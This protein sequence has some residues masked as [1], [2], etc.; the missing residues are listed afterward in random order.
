MQI[1]VVIV[2]QIAKVFKLVVLNKEQW[3]YTILISLVPLVIIEM[4]KKFEEIKF[5]KVV[6]QTVDQK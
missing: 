1:I 4:Q 5:G 3:I 6:Y 2:P